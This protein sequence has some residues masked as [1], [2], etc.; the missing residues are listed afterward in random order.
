[1]SVLWVQIHKYTQRFECLSNTADLTPSAGIT[2]R[3]RAI[4]NKVLLVELKT[5]ER[6]LQVYLKVI[7]LCFCCV[8]STTTSVFVIA[9]PTQWKTSEAKSI[10][11][12]A[13]LALSI[14][15]T[16]NGSHKLFTPPRHHTRGRTL[17][18]TQVRLYIW[19]TYPQ[20]SQSH[21][22]IVVP[23]RHPLLWVW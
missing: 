11:L 15:G 3:A 1:M 21:L 19:D 12:Q 8:R 20:L 10:T 13:M 5:E 6:W 22:P 2:R 4:T 14:P 17:H 23:K 9:E 7:S 16:L 18:W